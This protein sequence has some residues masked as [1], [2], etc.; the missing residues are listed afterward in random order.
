MNTMSH[1]ELERT[2]KAFAN[3]RRLAIVQLIQKRKEISV[4]DVAREIRVSIKATSKHLALLSGVGVLDKEQ[5]G[6]NM[7]YRLASDMPDPA[8]KILSFL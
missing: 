3:K 4:G 8:R 1:K 6:T 2:L 5:R 7:F